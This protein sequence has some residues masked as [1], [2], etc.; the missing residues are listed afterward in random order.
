MLVLVLPA[1]VS[2]SS[3]PD[4]EIDKQDAAAGARTPSTRWWFSLCGTEQG[5]IGTKE[6]FLPRP[7]DF[8]S[9]DMFE[10]GHACFLAHSH[11]DSHPETTDT[12]WCGDR[13]QR[14]GRTTVV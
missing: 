6:V 4:L 2:V 8:K 1:L 10:P 11:P 9:E 3:P 13:L 7:N 12:V 5:L 14:S